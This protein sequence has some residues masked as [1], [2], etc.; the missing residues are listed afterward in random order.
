LE[1]WLILG[2]GLGKN[3]ISL[4]QVTPSLTSPIKDGIMSKEHKIQIEGTTN[5]QTWNNLNNEINNAVFSSNEN[6]VTR[7]IQRIK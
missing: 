3:E 2:L 1:K 7:I 5:S 6:I 4:E